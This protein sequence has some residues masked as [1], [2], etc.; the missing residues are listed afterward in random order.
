MV[1]RGHRQAPGQGARA[2]VQLL[3]Q[4][5]RGAAGG[6]VVLAHEETARF[7]EAIIFFFIYFLRLS[8]KCSGKAVA[9]DSS[10]RIGATSFRW[11]PRRWDGRS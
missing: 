7:L 10:R 2:A 3:S 1:E 5:A 4:V 11:A 6:R 9:T 8:G